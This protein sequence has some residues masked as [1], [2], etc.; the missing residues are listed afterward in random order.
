M[1]KE[2]TNHKRRSPSRVAKGIQSVFLGGKLNNWAG[3]LLFGLIAVS[4]ALLLAWNINLGIGVFGFVVGLAGLIVCLMSTESAFYFNMA[5][6]FFVYHLSRLLFDGQVPVGVVTD[7]LIV[8]ILLSMFIKGISLKTSL[9][10]FIRSPVVILMVLSFFY[11]SLELFNP[12]GH[13]VEAWTQAIRKAFE[14]F[15][16]LFIAFQFFKEEGNIRRYIRVLFVLCVIVALYGCIQQWH[17]LFDFELRWATEDPLRFGLLFINGEFRKF[18]TFNDPTSFGGIMAACGVFFSVLAMGQR[19][20]RIRRILLAGVVLMVLAM[21]FSGT[22][23]ANVMLV[24]GLGM[25]GLLTIDKRRTWVFAAIG[26]ILLVG[27]LFAP[28]YG[29]S[30]INRFRSS[31]MNSDDE[32]YKV[33]VMARDFIRPY[34]IRHPF[35]GGLGTTGNLGLVLN[36]TSP[37]AGFQTDSGYLQLALETGWIGLIIVCTMYYY[38]LR[39]GVRAYFHSR[40]EEMKWVYAAATCAL[41]SYYV[42]MF[43]Q[44]MIGSI[45]DMAFYYPVLAIILRF[46]FSPNT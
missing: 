37:L 1:N 16:F 45:T 43:A 12:E 24:A 10:E 18:S 35:G 17:G 20:K 19:D 38:I 25:F 26:L 8:V 3:V 5:S 39:S 23:T 4:M 33:R 29:N 14:A 22:R 28:I 6:S 30:T 13:S 34:M 42:G 27:V 11:S 41:F 32:S 31:F 36:P 7:V 40:D 15:I 44:S 46:K 2:F 9:N 21:A